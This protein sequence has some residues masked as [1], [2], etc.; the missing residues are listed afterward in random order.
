MKVIQKRNNMLDVTIYLDEV[1]NGY[2][3]TISGLGESDVRIV[4]E[5]LDDLLRALEEV[6]INK[7]GDDNAKSNG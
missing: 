4:G 6:L 1:Y 2:H 3:A 7:Q 5:N